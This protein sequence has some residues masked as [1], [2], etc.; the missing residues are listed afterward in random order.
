VNSP[1]RAL[2]DLPPFGLSQ[3][4]K[5][6]RLLPMLR[7]LTEYHAERCTPYRNILNNVFGGTGRL[8]TERLEDIPFLPVTLFKT[9]VLSSVPQGHVVKV[10]TSSGTTGQQPSRI[11][12]DAETASVQSAV[13]VKV[14]QHFLGRERLPMVIVDH[15]GVVR[16]RDSRSARGAGILGMAQ[17]GHRPF[18]ALRE[19]M[20]L[21]LEGLRAYLGQAEGRRVLF[22]GF[23]FMVWRYLVEA[24]ERAR[25]RLVIQGGTLVHSGGWKKLQE[26]AVDP[27]TFRSRVQAATGV[28]Q[29]I[30]FYGMVEQVGGVYF[31]N[32]IHYLHAPIYSEVI[33]RDPVTLAPLPDGQPG[34]IQV[35]SCLPTSYPGHSL[36]TEDLG[37]VRGV[38]PQGTGMGGRYFEVVGRVPRAELRGCSDTFAASA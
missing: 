14:A 13:L 28:E 27:D 22:F 1:A 32:P 25:Q 3:A 15:P 11:F 19:D 33:V 8:G 36:L 26:A 2:L 37:V 4:E 20:S 18:Y 17:F 12:L 23:T 29:V 35:L 6:A 7:A 38:D 10:L 9:H 34:L 30:N 24:L 21:D 31:E 5:R 16:D